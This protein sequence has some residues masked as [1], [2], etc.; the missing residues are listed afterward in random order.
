MY[1]IYAFCRVVDDIA[2][3]EGR[4]F[5]AKQARAGRLARPGRSP[6]PRRGRRAR[7]PA[8]CCGVIA[9]YGL[10][11]ADFLAIIDGMEMDAGDAD[12]RPQPGRARPLLR[13]RRLRRRPAFGARLRRSSPAADEVAHAL[14][15]GAAAHEYPARC[16]RGCAARRGSICRA[17]FW[18]RPACRQTRAALP[19]GP[20][21][22]GCVQRASPRMARRRI[23]RGPRR[24]WRA[25][26]RRAM[27][28]A[29]LMA[30]SY[31]PLLAIL[32]R[33]SSTIQRR[34]AS[35]CRNG[36]SW[37]LAACLLTA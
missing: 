18:P 15:R 23:S 19:R 36:G 10:R 17:N 4:D 33:R 24:R 6:L 1:A 5:A 13:P 8:R 22:A 7:S 3:E 12:H 34:R 29:R 37:S 32:R 26:T 30:A 27:R 28:P 20:E 2:D 35:R 31:R 11:E 9:D 14:G 25:A 21:S 16:R